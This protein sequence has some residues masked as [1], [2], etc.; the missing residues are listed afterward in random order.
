[1]KKQ[2]KKTIKPI[3]QRLW[4]TDPETSSHWKIVFLKDSGEFSYK[5][6]V[7][8]NKIIFFYQKVAKT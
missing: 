1:M 2:K 6:L 7:L 3:F 8:L 4:R 5:T